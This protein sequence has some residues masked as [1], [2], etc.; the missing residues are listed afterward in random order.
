MDQAN[1][2]RLLEDDSSEAESNESCKNDWGN[3]PYPVIHNIAK[4]LEDDKNNGF[5]MKNILAVNQHWHDVLL[6][7]RP[8]FLRIDLRDSNIDRFMQKLGDKSLDGLKHVRITRFDNRSSTDKKKLTEVMKILNQKNFSLTSLVLEYFRINWETGTG[9]PDLMEFFDKHCLHLE[10]LFALESI[11][12]I[13]HDA[14]QNRKF[15]HESIISSNLASITHLELANCPEMVQLCEWEKLQNLV[16]LTIDDVFHGDSVLPRI[17]SL[18]N[19]VYGLS[20]GFPKLKCLKFYIW[21]RTDEDPDDMMDG[22]KALEYCFDNSPKL[23]KILLFCGLVNNNFNLKSL[24]LNGLI[25]G[26][27][28]EEYEREM[29]KELIKIISCKNHEKSLEKIELVCQSRKNTDKYWKDLTKR[30]WKAD[31]FPELIEKLEKCL[32]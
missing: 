9:M 13:C 14:P 25:Q 1:K 16:N 10:A 17:S 19:W 29:T 18:K 22:I 31:E 15:I 3:L 2:I 5:R 12:C 24:S 11:V 21:L 30:L 26:V 28:T 32:E 7:Y 4:H 23:E 6:N 8:K 20:I 27:R